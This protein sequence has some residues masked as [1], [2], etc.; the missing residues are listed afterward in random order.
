L[1]DSAR[2]VASQ[3]DIVAALHSVLGLSLTPHAAIFSFMVVAVT[4][5]VPRISFFLSLPPAK[6]LHL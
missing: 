4:P 3:I 2:P 6:N 5:G 1:A